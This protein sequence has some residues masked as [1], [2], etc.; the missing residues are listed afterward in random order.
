MLK[1]VYTKK[2]QR[3]LF[4]IQSYIWEDSVFYSLKVLNNI[5]STI[6]ILKDFPKIGIVIE[7]ETRFIIEKNYKY[8]I[9]YELKWGII[10]I[11]SVYKYKNSWE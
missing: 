5:Q 8:K 11:L 3:D 7:E 6:N 10:Y 1:I 4:E 9:V 2:F